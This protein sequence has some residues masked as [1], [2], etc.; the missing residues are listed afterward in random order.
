M[1]KASQLYRSDLEFRAHGREE[2]REISITSIAKPFRT[3][4][5]GTL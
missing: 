5:R 2:L 4:I 1:K 3:T